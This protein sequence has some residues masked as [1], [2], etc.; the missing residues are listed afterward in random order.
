MSSRVALFDFDGTLTSRDS[1][2]PFLRRVR[3]SARLMLDLVSVSPWLAGYAA[4]LIENNEAK[5][6]LLKQC[7]GGM[8]MDDIEPIALEFVQ[9]GLP[10][11]LRADTLSRLRE[12]QDRGDLCILV[13]A[14]LDIYLE[15]WGRAEGF[16][17]VIASR[18]EQDEKACI[19]GRLA[20]GNCHG[21]EKAVRVKRLLANLEVSHITAYG[22]SAGDWPML[23][24]ADQAHWVGKYARAT[25]K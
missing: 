21:M 5:E 4:R 12:H 13:S 22:D 9:T 19:T 20:G 14:S 24:L 16:H 7:L 10:D 15:P 11:L 8:T 1:L 2:L 25:R 18:L 3:G 6:A 17:H 23:A